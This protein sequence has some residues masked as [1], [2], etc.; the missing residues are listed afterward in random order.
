MN[1][2]VVELE[3]CSVDAAASISGYSK[4]CASAHKYLKAFRQKNI[5]VYIFHR[6]AEGW[7]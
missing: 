4:S 2:F 3:A 6:K 1:I 7:K 5:A